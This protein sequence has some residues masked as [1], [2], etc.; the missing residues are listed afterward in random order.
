LYKKVLGKLKNLLSDRALITNL[1]ARLII[2]FGV[3]LIVG[4]LYLMITDVSASTQAQ[5]TG[6]LATSAVSTLDWIPGIPFYIGD[7]ANASATAIGLVSWILGVDFVLVGL[8]LWIRSGLAR[9]AALI[10]FV[11]AAYFQFVQFLL[12]GILGSPISIIEFS[13]DGVF[14]YFL[15][16]KF[17]SQKS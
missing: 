13:I 7:L 11:L 1:L 17:D 4:G 5:Q 9:L 15:F 6:L 2:A 10:I 8:G 12:L 16:S 3:V 14:A